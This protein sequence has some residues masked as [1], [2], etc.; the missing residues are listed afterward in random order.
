M[1]SVLVENVGTES[2]GENSPVV[3]VTPLGYGGAFATTEGHSSFL[4][5]DLANG[6]NLL[7]DC[8]SQV[9]RELR[10]RELTDKITA[11]YITHTHEDHIGSLSGLIYENWFVHKKK[12]VLFCY[13][14]VRHRLQ[15]YL[16]TVCHHAYDQ[17][18]AVYYRD[19]VVEKLFPSF[20][21]NDFNTSGKHFEAFPSSGVTLKI[22]DEQRPFEIVF[23]G[24]LGVPVW[25][26]LNLDDTDRI[27]FQDAGTYEFTTKTHTVIPHAFYKDCDREGVWLYHHFKHEVE[28][29][30]QLTH[31]K[32]IAP[33]VEGKQHILIVREP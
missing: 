10:E 15:T 30:N 6:N 5:T 9:Y 22:K 11:I 31:A 20:D 12:T 23:S 25:D 18:E 28:A 14:E 26:V 3:K 13:P 16:T 7:I 32:S 1:K 4:I 33:V 21:I 2:L 24:D 27:I 19:E 8:G 17:F 29:I